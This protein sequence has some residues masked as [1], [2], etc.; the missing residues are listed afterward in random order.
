MNETISTISDICGILGFIISVFAASQVLK[1]KQRI[2]G[3]N[4]NNVNM[5]GNVGG[6]FIGRDRH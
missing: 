2:K 5:K 6:D 3:D 4:N 1:L